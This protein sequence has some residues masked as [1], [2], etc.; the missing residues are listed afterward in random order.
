MKNILIGF[1][2]IFLIASMLNR[3]EMR[4]PSKGANEVTGVRHFVIPDYNRLARQT[5]VQGDVTV[6]VHIRGDGT[7]GAIADVRGPEAL[8]QEVTK[9]LMSWTFDL[10]TAE[11]TE[12]AMTF[13]FSLQGLHKQ[14]IQ[15]YRVSGEFP[16][17][18]E[19]TV[20][21]PQTSWPSD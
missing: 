5:L 16:T 13:R 14:E 18:V 11:P 17:L 8:S 1:A 4:A 7:V 20:N 10:R 15:F 3:T 9:A 12:H 21:P 19:V 6:R 2:S